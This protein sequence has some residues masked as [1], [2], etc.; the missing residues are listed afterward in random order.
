MTD[1]YAVIGNPIAQS[2]SPLI[3]ATFAELTGQDLVYDKIEAPLDGFAA[4]V[5]V[6]RA[7]GGRGLNITAPFKLDAAAYATQVSERVKLLQAFLQQR[8]AAL[9]VHNSP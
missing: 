4:A 6:F 1:R 5:D 8:C 2:K 9:L 7:A 3:H